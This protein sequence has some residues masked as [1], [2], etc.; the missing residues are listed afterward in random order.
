MHSSLNRVNKTSLA[1]FLYVFMSSFFL[2]ATSFQ[3]DNFNPSTQTVDVT[4][5]F[6]EGDVD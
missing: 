6:D 2:M 5:D 3:L 1:V 4:Y